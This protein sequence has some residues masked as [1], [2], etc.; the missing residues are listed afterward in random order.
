MRQHAPRTTFVGSFPGQLPELGLPEVAFVGRSNVGK[1]SALNT[2]LGKKSAARVS[3]TP[4]RTQA[5]N[6]FRLGD[7]LCFADLPGYG[8][9]KVPAAVQQA[10]KPMIERYLGER[11]ALRLV[12]VLVDARHTARPADKDLLD[13][14]AEADIPFLVVATKL[15]K[16]SKHARKPTLRALAQG[17]G[18]GDQA[19]LGFSS[20]SGEGRDAVW[21]RI[22]AACREPG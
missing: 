20:L 2:L 5:I 12:V 7:A 10:W 22:E 1:S 18:L 4:G 19:L 6:L 13:G 9:A 14:L 17:L 21:E 15:D 3:S 8:F 11:E 16:L